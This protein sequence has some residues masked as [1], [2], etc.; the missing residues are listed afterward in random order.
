MDVILGVIR[1]IIILI[2]WTA[3]A[4]FVNGAKKRDNA[5]RNAGKQAGQNSKK[6]STKAV[7]QPAAKQTPGVTATHDHIQSTELPHSRKLEQL[8]VLKDA[9]L[10]TQEEY[11]QRYQKILKGR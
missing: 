8:K 1:I 11:D 3:V 10:L 2:F 6:V 5:R 4:L 7:Y 9:G